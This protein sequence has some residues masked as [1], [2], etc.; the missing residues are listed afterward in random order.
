MARAHTSGKT[1]CH[2]LD[3]SELK[4]YWSRMRLL[5]DGESSTLQKQTVFRLASF[6]YSSIFNSLINLGIIMQAQSFCT[7]AF[8][9]VQALPFSSARD[10][11]KCTDRTGVA[12]ESTFH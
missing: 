1:N 11:G 4:S 8:P 10:P 3:I 2:G 12:W 6:P 9:S 5:R 7:A